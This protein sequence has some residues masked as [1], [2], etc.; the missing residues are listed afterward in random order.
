MTPLEGR[1]VSDE[2][3][4]IL[5][6][7]LVPLIILFFFVNMAWII[8]IVVDLFTEGFRKPK[9]WMQLF[10]W[11]II[12]TAWIYTVSYDWFRSTQEI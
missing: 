7:G 1:T 5:F 9:N 10:L 6:L 2:S 11:L 4:L 8:K 12:C 3:V